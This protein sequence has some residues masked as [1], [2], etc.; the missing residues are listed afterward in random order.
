[1]TLLTLEVVSF[2]R[3]ISAEGEKC[4]KLNLMRSHD[5]ASNNQQTVEKTRPT[6]PFKNALNQD[7]TLR[8]GVGFH[9]SHLRRLST[10]DNEV[11]GRELIFG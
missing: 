8:N 6:E 2:K 1:L 3:S 5:P 11:R 10:Y 4:I 7:S 9:Y